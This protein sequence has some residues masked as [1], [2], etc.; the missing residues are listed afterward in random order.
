M[1]IKRK[2]LLLILMKR[3]T[4]CDQLFLLEI[5][6]VEENMETDEGRV[7]LAHS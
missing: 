5:Q 3:Y 7:G 4:W 6:E 2:Q 1:K